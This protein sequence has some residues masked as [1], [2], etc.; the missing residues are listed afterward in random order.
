MFDIEIKTCQLAAPCSPIDRSRK[1]NSLAN[2]ISSFDYRCDCTCEIF[3]DYSI[4]VIIWNETFANRK[5]L[6]LKLLK[7]TNYIYQTT[8]NK[9]KYTF[10]Q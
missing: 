3:K 4:G 7:G 5:S 2:K 9:W 8:Y 6:N 1:L 10:V